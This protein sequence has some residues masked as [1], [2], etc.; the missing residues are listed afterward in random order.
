MK[1]HEQLKEECRLAYVDW[2]DSPRNQNKNKAYTEA[3]RAFMA[4]LKLGPKHLLE[5][6]YVSVSLPTIAGRK[7]EN[8]IDP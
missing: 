7:Y 4:C 5:E 3:F 2:A 8:T 6:Y 1:T